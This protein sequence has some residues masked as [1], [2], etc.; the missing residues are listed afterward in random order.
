M[1]FVTSRGD[2]REIL[3]RHL[4]IP[5]PELGL[6]DRLI[7][8][9]CDGSVVVGGGDDSGIVGVVGGGH[10]VTSRFRKSKKGE[11]QK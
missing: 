6:D 2:S 7:A 4:A 1:K 10:G 3:G 11:C 5:S 8:D 9:G